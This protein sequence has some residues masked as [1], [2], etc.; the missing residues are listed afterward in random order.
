M[1]RNLGGMSTTA[2]RCLDRLPAGSQP[3]SLR[4]ITRLQSRERRF[5]S[6]WGTHL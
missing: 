2:R 4:R 3:I 5:E 6:Y 1:I